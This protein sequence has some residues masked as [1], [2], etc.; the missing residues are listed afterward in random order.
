M[1]LRLSLVLVSLVALLTGCATAPQLPVAVSPQVLATP[2]TRIGVVMTA[3]PKVDTEFPGAYCL[4]CMVAASATNSTL[5]DYTRTLPYEELPQL[6]NQLAD[7]LTKRGATV[8]MIDKVDFDKLPDYSP[9]TPNFARK[10][11]S[12]LKAQYNV[13]K[14]VVI[15]LTGVGIERT[16]S[17]YI[18]TADP[19]AR[20][21]GV[22]YLVNLNSN[23]LEWYLPLNVQKASDGKWDEPAKFPGLTNAYFQVLEMTKDEVLKPFQN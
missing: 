10:N 5:T 9:A 4:L 2:G 14:L 7:V 22:S 19:K 6:K 12:A 21:A 23:A 11:F 3:L 1:N 16:Y 8:V 18:P 17:A 15:A 20:V 13:D